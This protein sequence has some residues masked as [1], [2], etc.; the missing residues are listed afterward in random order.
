MNTIQT[1]TEDA[2]MGTMKTLIND[3]MQ[4]VMTL[5]SSPE[6]VLPPVIKLPLAR[7]TFTLNGLLGGHVAVSESPDFQSVILSVC[8]AQNQQVEIQL[9]SEHFGE[10]SYL[11]YQL[12]FATEQRSPF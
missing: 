8:N 11:R 6:P 3:V 1:T 2:S 4:D 9:D 10:L 12:F 7:R 5:D